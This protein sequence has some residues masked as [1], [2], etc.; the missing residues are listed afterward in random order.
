MTTYKYLIILF[1]VIISSC[2]NE[3]NTYHTKTQVDTAKKI[4]NLKPV[5]SALLEVWSDFQL[6]AST[7]DLLQFRRLSLDSLNTCDSTMSTNKFI[8]KCYNEVFDTT[9]LRKITIPTEINQIN[10]SMELGYFSKSILENADFKGDAITLKQFQ[11]VKELTPDGG[12]IITFDFIK[13][14]QGY[15]FFG[16]GS[17]GGAICCR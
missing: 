12:W 9:L 1:V 17:Y 10:V 15:K 4:A 14:K 2:G 7:K 5:D 3:A 11:L 6:A 16:C 8:K 13:T